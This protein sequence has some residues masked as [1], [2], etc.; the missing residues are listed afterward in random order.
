MRLIAGK[1][2]IDYLASLDGRT[3]IIIINLLARYGLGSL[4]LWISQSAW[5]G[6]ESLVIILCSSC[7]G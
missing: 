1:Y 6:W 4:F 3:L 5:E 7:R 2:G